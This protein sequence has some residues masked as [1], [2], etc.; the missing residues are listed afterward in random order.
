MEMLKWQMTTVA[1]SHKMLLL[2][3]NRTASNTEVVVSLPVFVVHP[4]FC[5]YWTFIVF[6]LW[7]SDRY[8]WRTADWGQCSITCGSAGT[9]SRTVSCYQFRYNE[10]GT[11]FEPSTE[12]S[13]GH[14]QEMDRPADITEC[15]GR[16][17]PA[18]WRT[19]KWGEVGSIFLH[20]LS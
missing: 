11:L 19:E 18:N 8:E 16:L 15:Q 17:C 4:L 1:L 5:T 14:C 13:L 6:V 9:K 12:V 3:H 2:K 7:I 20:G 10:D